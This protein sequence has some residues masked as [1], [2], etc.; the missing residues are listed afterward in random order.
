MKY[1]ALI[2]C[3]LS[4]FCMTSCHSGQE[5]K[6]YGLFTEWYGRKIEIPLRM[7]KYLYACSS[8]LKMI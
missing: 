5:K 6:I 2:C 4:V 3:L 8:V 7:I 1:V